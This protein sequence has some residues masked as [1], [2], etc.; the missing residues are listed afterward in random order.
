MVLRELVK[1][2]DAVLCIAQPAHALLSGRLARAW[3]NGLFPAPWPREEVVVAV[4][5]HDVGMAEWD[6]EP[7][8]HPDTG[9]PRSFLEMAL[10]THLGLWSRAPRLAL[11]Q[12]RWAGLLVSMHG[13]FLYS[14]RDGEPGVPEFLDAQA[15]LQARLIE[16]LGVT[17]EQAA[18]NQRML[19]AWDWFSLVLCMDRLPETVQ[20]ERPISVTPG[21]D[22]VTVSPWP[23]AAEAVTV[24]TEG[25]VLK[26][27][28]EDEAEMRAALDAAAW[29]TLSWTLQPG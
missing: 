11:S 22:A 12:S 29:E 7:E 14:R 19:A 20:A 15:E 4:E 23:F 3:G 27:R 13:A 2:K 5:Q 24:S 26:Q 17:P 16:S 1:P 21:R 25:R 10:E 8:L 28:F 6:S 18:R 9:W